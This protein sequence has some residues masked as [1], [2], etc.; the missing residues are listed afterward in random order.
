M[1]WNDSLD[2]CLKKSTMLTCSCFLKKSKA[3]VI[4]L[5]WA[6][7]KFMKLCTCH[8]SG[9]LNNQFFVFRRSHSTLKKSLVAPKQNFKNLRVGSWR[10]L[11]PQ[12]MLD[13]SRPRRGIER[14][15]SSWTFIFQRLEFA[16]MMRFG[17]IVSGLRVSRCRLKDVG[18][19][20]RRG[21]FASRG[22]RLLR[23]KTSKRVVRETNWR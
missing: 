4:R 17:I 21:V 8:T 20:T 1:G 11:L 2:W 7:S 22:N 23:D 10:R 5:N 3:L 18:R 19:Y 12:V 14:T 15:S 13:W 9:G 16:E 6:P